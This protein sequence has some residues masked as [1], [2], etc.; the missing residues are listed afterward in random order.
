MILSKGE[1]REGGQAKRE[2]CHLQTKSNIAHPPSPYHNKLLTQLSP[3]GETSYGKKVVFKI[4]RHIN[5]VF[6]VLYLK[7]I[8]TVLKKVFENSCRSQP[9]ST[10][11]DRYISTS[12]LTERRARHVCA[13]IFF[14]RSLK[15]R[16]IKCSTTRLKPNACL[17][18]ASSTLWLVSDTL[19]RSV[20]SFLD[21]RNHRFWHHLLERN[22]RGGLCTPTAHGWP[23]FS[24]FRCLV[25]TEG[26]GTYVWMGGRERGRG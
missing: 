2:G 8:V 23:A 15:R 10:F 18:M 14:F 13:W 1:E 26:I 4:A 24:F 25:S 3:W 17:P 19:R 20:P 12:F 22:F 16:V 9:M 21:D 11:T 7:K 6:S 5:Y